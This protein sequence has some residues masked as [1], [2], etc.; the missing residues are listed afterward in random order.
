MSSFNDHQ[1]QPKGG[2]SQSLLPPI[3]LFCIV[4]VLET[5][6]G[7]PSSVSDRDLASFRSAPASY[8]HQLAANIENHQN[9]LQVLLHRTDCCWSLVVSGADH[10][11]ADELRKDFR[12]TPEQ[13]MQ[14]PLSE[15]YFPPRQWAHLAIG[16]LLNNIKEEP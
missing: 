5:A 9:C 3:C 12:R 11:V 4:R 7:H 6:S 2:P 15:Q 16:K 10:S 8:S 14:V 13:C 1:Q